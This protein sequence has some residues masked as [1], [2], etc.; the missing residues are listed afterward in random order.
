MLKSIFEVLDLKCLAL[1]AALLLSISPVVRAQSVCLPLPRLLTTM[2][3][4]GAVGSEFEVTISGE[5]IDGAGELQFS[6]PAITATPKLGPSGAAEPNKYVV[7]VAA[8]CAPGLYEA[9]LM[10]RLGI[11]SSRIF[12][13]DTLKE[14][15]QETPNLSFTTAKELPVNTI[16]NSV[17]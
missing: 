4:G 5:N 2:P 16:C 10:T 1:A 9:R 3:M 8:D 14:T 11:S 7:K 17:M 12:C 6:T 15:K 13:I